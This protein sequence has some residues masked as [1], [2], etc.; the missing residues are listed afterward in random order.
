[1]F[2][3]VFLNSLLDFFNEQPILFVLFL[4]VLIYYKDLKPIK[5]ALNNHITDTTKK[6][7]KLET[8]LKA[9]QIKLET[10]LRSGQKEL[11]SKIDTLITTLLGNKVEISPKK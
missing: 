9:G 7:E 6:I 11:N 5:V 8:E 2:D 3:L 4:Y 10:E 1:M